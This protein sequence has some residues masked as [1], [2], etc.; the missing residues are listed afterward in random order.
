M[1]T[2]VDEH[3]SNETANECESGAGVRL[4]P[5]KAAAADRASIARDQ[6]DG[7]QGSEQCRSTAMA[8]PYRGLVTATY[9]RL[10]PEFWSANRAEHHFADGHELV[11]FDLLAANGYPA[12]IG[13]EL[14]GGPGRHD[15]GRV[16]P[17]REPQGSQGLLR[18]SAGSGVGGSRMFAEG[19]CSSSKV[20]RTLKGA[21]PLSPQVSDSGGHGWRHW[22]ASQRGR[23]V[24]MVTHI[25]AGCLNGARQGQSA[26][27]GVLVLVSA[28]GEVPRDNQGETAFSSR[29]SRNTQ[30]SC[31][32]ARHDVGPFRQGAPGTTEGRPCWRAPATRKRGIGDQ[33]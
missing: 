29:L 10:D 6:R 28:I 32:L 30:G 26:Q 31:R 7:R 3:I 2:D 15:A 13:W 11:A 14:F 8:R 27:A 9:G 16:G 19:L 1:S 22:W 5:W 18:D 23:G 12:T 24:A 25:V 33:A 21:M 20:G 4:E 17:G